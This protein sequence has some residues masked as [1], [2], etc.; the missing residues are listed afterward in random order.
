MASSRAEST[1]AAWLAV[2][3]KHKLDPD[4]P[5]A[6]AMWSPRLD[7]ASRDELSAISRHASGADIN[8]WA[9]SSS[10]DEPHTDSFTAIRT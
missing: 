7:G 9:E 2:L 4:R 6:K 5:A 8:I 3:D 10:A 1:R